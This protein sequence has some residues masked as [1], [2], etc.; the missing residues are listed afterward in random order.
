MHTQLSIATSC[1]VLTS[2]TEGIRLVLSTHFY[3]LP[4]NRLNP[5]CSLL[6]VLHTVKK[7]HVEN[8]SV[9]LSVHYYPIQ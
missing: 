8:C 3:H 7:I 4:K 1:P 2:V 9:L 5:R 6:S